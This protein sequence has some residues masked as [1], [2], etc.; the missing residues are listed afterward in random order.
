MTYAQID[1]EDILEE[2]DATQ[3]SLSNTQIS[4]SNT[5]ISLSNTQMGLSNTQ[6]SLSNTQMGLSN[7][8]VGLSNTQVGLSNTQVGLSN[9]QISLSNTQ[10]SLSNTQ[11]SLS[12][13]QISLSNTQVSL[14]NTQVGLS[15]TQVG[16]SNTQISLSNTQIS[17]S[18]TQVDVEVLKNTD[19]VLCTE[20]IEADVLVGTVLS[21]YINPT[22]F[23]NEV[24][25]DEHWVKADGRTLQR[26]DAIE[27]FNYLGLPSWTTSTTVPNLTGNQQQANWTETNVTSPSYIQ[28]KPSIPAAQVQA[29]WSE[30][31]TASLAFIQNKP[32]LSTYVPIGVVFPTVASTVPD[33]TW[34]LC[35]GSTY[36]TADYPLLAAALG[37]S[38]STFIVPDMR[39]RVL[40]G[41][42]ATHAL[43]S[44]GG[45]DTQTLSTANIPTHTHGA[46][47]LVF[48]YTGYT[49]I[50]GGGTTKVMS[51]ISG[52]TNTMA[53][54][55][56]TGSA[57]LG[58][59]FSI[60]NKYY[61][62]NYIIKAK[63]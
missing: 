43:L 26:A 35:N 51:D 62:V 57:G 48:N 50:S 55:G 61:T 30:T 49:N 5:Q 37:V 12:N 6:I 25:L 8:Q 36:N 24:D 13:T 58:T 31:N 9:T 56:S 4:L 47:S 40:K 7:T 1:Q 52:G 41:T 15:N 18:N 60:E 11:I 27:Y 38:T 21:R 32:T 10:I 59:A 39:G 53:I 14:S 20:E 54:T 16:L 22:G 45:A 33:A 29:N 46:G 28:N 19:Y 44:T 3:V 42:D 2:I 23:L 34:L 17:L 63:Y